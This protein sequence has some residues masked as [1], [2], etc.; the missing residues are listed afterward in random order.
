MLPKKTLNSDGFTVNCT[1]YQSNRNS[2]TKE[3]NT[4]QF[5]LL[6]LHSLWIQ[7]LTRTLKE[8]EFIGQSHSWSH[9]KILSEILANESIYLQEGL[10]T[11]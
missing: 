4:S 7:S 2:C 10:Y 1:R 3:G 11:P 6:V 8:T 5:I 9:V